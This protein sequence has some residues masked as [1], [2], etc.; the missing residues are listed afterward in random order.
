MTAYELD[1]EWKDWMIKAASLTA[2]AKVMSKTDPKR[3]VFLDLARR[4]LTKATEIS[5][6][7]ER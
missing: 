1:A 7:G 2:Q 5:Q 6:A 4:A 3:R